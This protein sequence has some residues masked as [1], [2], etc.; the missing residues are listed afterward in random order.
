MRKVDGGI[1]F[2]F[3]S[4]SN[5][6]EIDPERVYAGGI[7]AYNTP[8]S[9]V[10]VTEHAYYITAADTETTFFD[11][12]DG[13]GSVAHKTVTFGKPCHNLTP[14]S[15]LTVHES[16]VN[17]AI[18]SGI[19]TLTG[20]EYTHQ[21]KIVSR[22]LS[23]ATSEN[24]VPVKEAT[25]I[26]A[27]NSGSVADRVLAYYSGAK[28]LSVSVVAGGER[29]G[30]AVYLE[31]AFGDL[32]SGLLQSMSI[33]ISSTLKADTTIITGYIPTHHGSDYNNSIILNGSGA[34]TVPAGVTKIKRALIGGGD[35]GSGG[36]DGTNGSAGDYTYYDPRDAWYTG[37]S[38]PGNGGSKG[39]KGQG[40]KIY[41]DEISV[42]PGQQIPYNCGIGGTG[43]GIGATG[44]SGTDTTFGSA[45]S[46]SGVRSPYGFYDYF[47]GIAYGTDGA[48][49]YDGAAGGV[50]VDTDSYPE[51]ADYEIY[52]YDG[53]PGGD[54]LD[55][56]RGGYGGIRTRH[57]SG[58][59]NQYN[60]GAA[61]G[62]SGGGATHNVEGGPGDNGAF[63]QTGETPNGFPIYRVTGGGGGDGANA[64]PGS[65]GAQY[66]CGGDGG[67]GGGGGGCPG[68][69]FG[70][71]DSRGTKMLVQQGDVGLG[72]NGS[73]GGDGADGCVIIYF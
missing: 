59:Q 65:A 50:G 34:W 68:G 22:R 4:A 25:L 5:P 56:T 29:P 45:S 66:G 69:S 3:L 62:G 61:C 71:T 63:V 13:S 57:Q 67:D 73:D 27:V 1:S 18:I 10:D 33:R 48:D 31:D 24:I 64:V 12:T 58:T 2:A 15:G 16:G 11:N 70:A 52:P 23:A 55:G 53:L 26:T 44:G 21:T 47:G 41:S 7:L 43:G 42:T 54:C 9:G 39:M 28:T 60:V 17:Y 20:K 40:G 37:G 6:T 32:T 14:S 49:G 46:A 38:S 8:A 19:G 30:D 51:N 72:G 35:G 36:T